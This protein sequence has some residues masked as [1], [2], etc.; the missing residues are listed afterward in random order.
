MPSNSFIGLRIL[1]CNRV[2]GL[3]GAEDP[4]RTGSVSVEESDVDTDPIAD[5]VCVGELCGGIAVEEAAA[6]DPAAAVEGDVRTW[7]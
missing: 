5:P 3:G 2:T 4:W 1:F 7:S 6:E